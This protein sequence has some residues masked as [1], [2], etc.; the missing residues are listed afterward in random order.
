MDGRDNT[1][2]YDLVLFML[3]LSITMSGIALLTLNKSS[4]IVRDN[5]HHHDLVI[6]NTHQILTNKINKSIVAN[7][8]I[9]AHTS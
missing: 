3:Q 7:I 9:G 2:L 6:P 5:T 4:F 1:R 8:A